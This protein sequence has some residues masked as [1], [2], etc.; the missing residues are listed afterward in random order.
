MSLT[1]P[2]V[3][4]ATAIYRMKKKKKCFEV[5]TRRLDFC[6]RFYWHGRCLCT[7]L[8][9]IFLPSVN[10]LHYLRLCLLCS[11]SLCQLQS[12]ALV[13]DL[14]TWWSH[15]V[16]LA[17]ETSRHSAFFS[18]NFSVKADTLPIGFQTKRMGSGAIDRYLT[19]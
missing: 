12:M 5:E 9:S 10:S 6:L 16:V 14:N 17:T 3:I 15:T 7:F 13:L 8:L 18:G 19:V 4:K 11:Q 1:S 2:L